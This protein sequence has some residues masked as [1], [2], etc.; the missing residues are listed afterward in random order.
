M[1]P[2]RA[3]PAVLVVAVVALAAGCSDV[4]DAVK[5]KAN[6]AACSVAQ[7]TVD[8]V[9]GQVDD[10]IDEIGADPEAARRKLAGLRR[11]RRGPVRH[12]R[13]GQAEAA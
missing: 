10:A 5:G 2:R 8:G 6:E 7:K 13:G 4:E 1:S 11:P 12:Q 9:S 3:L